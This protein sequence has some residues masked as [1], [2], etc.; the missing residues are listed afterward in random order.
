[1]SSAGR[2]DSTLV[3]E[4]RVRKNSSNAG[5]LSYFNM[6]PGGKILI[7]KKLDIGKLNIR[8]LNIR[9]LAD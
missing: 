8:K 9:K 3:P 4:H 2:G 7:L 1:M 6:E 5:R